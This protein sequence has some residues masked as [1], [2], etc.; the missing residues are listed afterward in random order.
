MR[1]LH[2]FVGLRPGPGV[3][4]RERDL[5]AADCHTDIAGLFA[6]PR[7][8]AGLDQNKE[9]VVQNPQPSPFERV[10]EE[11]FAVTEFVRSIAGFQTM[12]RIFVEQMADQ[13]MGRSK[14]T[15]ETDLPE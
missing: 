11:G 12:Q 1:C 8:V 2:S 14:V 6:K 3:V 9:Q 4:K 7:L 5:L 15:H 10:I 13:T